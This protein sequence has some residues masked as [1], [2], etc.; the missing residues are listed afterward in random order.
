MVPSCPLIL[1]DFEV[2]TD[3]GK[4]RCR[5]CAIHSP[6]D[7]NGEW[8]LRK[9]AVAHQRSLVHRKSLERK[10]QLDSVLL[11][12]S[13]HEPSQNFVVAQNTPISQ[14]SR[15]IRRSYT[16]STKEIEMWNDFMTSEETFEMDAGPAELE[17]NRREEFERKI[18]E[19]GLWGGSEQPADLVSMDDIQSHWDEEEHNDLLAEILRNIGMLRC[20]LYI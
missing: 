14:S 4:V 11:D 12:E 9:S 1:A 16:I 19:H 15:E 5:T 13:R 3:D 7:Y 17:R 2:H 20:L 10:G 8:I 6:D 18:G